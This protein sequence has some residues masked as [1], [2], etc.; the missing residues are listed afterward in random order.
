[1]TCAHDMKCV[2]IC[3]CSFPYLQYLKVPLTIVYLPS[4]SE[5]AAAG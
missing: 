2:C 3:T 5:E 1:M 4:V